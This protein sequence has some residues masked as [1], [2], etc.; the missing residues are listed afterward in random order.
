MLFHLSLSR[1]PSL[2]NHHSANFKITLYNCPNVVRIATARWLTLASNHQ[3]A[4]SLNVTEALN[5]PALPVKLTS[6]SISAILASILILAAFLIYFKTRYRKVKRF[7]VKVGKASVGLL[8][9]KHPGQHHASAAVPWVSLNL[10]RTQVPLSLTLEHWLTG[11]E[12]IL[13]SVK[14]CAGWRLNF[15]FNENK[16]T[17]IQLFTH[18]WSNISHVL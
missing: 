11:Q 15:A 9:S 10:A 16:W 5:S 14:L 1:L 3:L 17:D 4:V 12:S 2:W 18:S 7:W 6:F 13:A 8:A